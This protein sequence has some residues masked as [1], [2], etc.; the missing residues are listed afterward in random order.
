MGPLMSSG[1]KRPLSKFNSSSV[2]ALG[3]GRPH[4]AAA[5]AG[6]SVGGWRLQAWGLPRGPMHLLPGIPRLQSHKKHLIAGPS[7][8]G[9]NT[10]EEEL[11]QNSN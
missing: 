11:M 8:G 6:G 10:E 4:K 1:R 7:G 5:R 9:W 2:G 3:P